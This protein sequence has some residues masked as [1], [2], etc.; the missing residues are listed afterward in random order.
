MRSEQLDCVSVERRESHAR[1]SNAAP[2]KANRSRGLKRLKNVCALF[3]LMPNAFDKTTSKLSSRRIDAAEHSLAEHSLA[4][5]YSTAARRL[6][7][8]AASLR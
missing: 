5:A 3:L 2:Q 4:W 8:Q 6:E 1:S 7:L